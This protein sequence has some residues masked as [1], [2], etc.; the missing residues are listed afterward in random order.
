MM[1]TLKHIMLLSATIPLSPANIA[2]G[3]AISEPIDD[4]TNSE[5]YLAEE[6]CSEITVAVV[7]PEIAIDTKDGKFYPTGSVPQ[8]GVLIMPKSD[9]TLPS[10]VADLTR[11]CQ[12]YQELTSQAYF[13]FSTEHDFIAP[14]LVWSRWHRA[15]YGT[16][17]NNYNDRASYQFYVDPHTNSKVQG[18][19]IG[20]API[21]ILGKL[22]IIQKWYNV[23]ITD[24]GGSA[25][26]TVP[27][28]KTA[29]YKE[30]RAQALNAIGARGTWR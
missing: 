14:S 30:F 18:Q 4:K 10:E 11:I 19:G 2:P 26:T 24:P 5:L 6:R 8:D 25:G 9:G 23:G 15:R 13:R 28:D 1:I 3:V 12:G 7:N 17:T 21:Y 29:G 20:Y 22:G 27:W 16:I